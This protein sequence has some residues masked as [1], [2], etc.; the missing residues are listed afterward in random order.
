M[1]MPNPS[2]TDPSLPAK[3]PPVIPPGHIAPTAGN[4][5]LGESSADR[6][7]I[8][9]VFA[10]VEAL[11]RQ[12]RRVM[13]QLRQPQAGALI[14]SLL[15]I[16]IICA[17]IYG[18]V[19][20]TFSGGTQLWAAP[21]KIVIGLLISALICLPSLYIF[22]CL[23]G[24]HARLVEVW[25]LVAGLLALMTVLLIGFAPVAWV[26]SQATKSLVAM[27]VIHLAFWGVATIFG[28]RF[29]SAGFSHFSGSAAGDFGLKIWMVIF[30]MVALQMSTAL[31]PIIGKADT[32]LP[33]AQDKKLF[34]VHWSDC[35]NGDSNKKTGGPGKEQ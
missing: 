35:V 34:L 16:A 24:S 7:P 33:S 22:S 20:G 14:A 8:R 25:G 1:E 21:A 31:R 30:L 2:S 9:G 12:P 10:T 19:A 28:M 5:P 6:E 18:V 3:P 13:Y 17:A 32:F 4:L 26:F 15:V 23:G 29:L 27:G 11:L